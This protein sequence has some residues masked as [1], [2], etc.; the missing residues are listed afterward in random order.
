MSNEFWDNLVHSGIGL[1]RPVRL[2]SQSNLVP[3]SLSRP[4]PA[5]ILKA[6]DPVNDVGLNRQSPE[7]GFH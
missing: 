7:S 4:R 6:E 1:D 3:S 2:K 5:A